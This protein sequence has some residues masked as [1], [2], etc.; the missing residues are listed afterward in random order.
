VIRRVPFVTRAAGGRGAVRE[1][2]DAILKAQGRW[3][4]VLG[5]FEVRR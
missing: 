5:W 2:V 3:R 1:A 4:E